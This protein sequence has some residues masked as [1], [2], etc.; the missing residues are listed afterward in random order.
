MFYTN[1]ESVPQP[2]H[3]ALDA[4]S[5]CQGMKVSN[6]MSK[7]TRCLDKAT[8]GTRHNPVDLEDGDPMAIDS[9]NGNDAFLSTLQGPT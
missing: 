2:I 4:M 8:A 6:M 5:D 1:A 9:D 3:E 7:L